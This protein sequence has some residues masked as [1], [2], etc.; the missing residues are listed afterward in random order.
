[1]EEEAGLAVMDT[2][3]NTPLRSVMDG[4]EC[5]WKKTSN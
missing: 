5:V 1:L 4:P 2:I 3:V